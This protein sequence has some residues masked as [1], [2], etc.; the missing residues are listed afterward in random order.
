MRTVFQRTFLD[1]STGEVMS[2]Q[3]VQV[4]TPVIGEGFA[5]VYQ[6]GIERVLKLDPLCVKVWLWCCMRMWSG[7]CDH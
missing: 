6:R 2:E 4:P 3:K 7:K 1:S 5:W